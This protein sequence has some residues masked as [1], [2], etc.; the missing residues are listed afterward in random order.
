M[1]HFNGRR[2]KSWFPCFQEWSSA[3]GVLDLDSSVIDD[4]NA[5]DRDYLEQFVAIYL[6]EDRMGLYDV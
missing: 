3:A 4:Y 2:V 1:R 6:L 5:V